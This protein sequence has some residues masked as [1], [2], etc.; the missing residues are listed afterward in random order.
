MENSIRS[1]PQ[2]TDFP[3]EVFTELAELLVDQLNRKYREVARERYQASLASSLQNKRRT[4]GDLVEKVNTL[5]TTIRLGE[6]G[7]A[8]FSKEDH[9]VALSRHLLKTY[10]SEIVNDMFLYVAEENLVKVSSFQRKG[11]IMC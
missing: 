3:D 11:Y 4:H 8:E 10:G 9:R 5:Y 7:I 2:L 6:K 1:L